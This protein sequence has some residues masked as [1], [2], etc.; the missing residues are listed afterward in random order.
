MKSAVKS[1][2]QSPSNASSRSS[3][4]ESSKQRRMHQSESSNQNATQDMVSKLDALYRL[5]RKQLLWDA[6]DRLTPTKFLAKSSELRSSLDELLPK[7]SLEVAFVSKTKSP[8]ESTI[9]LRSANYVEDIVKDDR[10][11]RSVI[12]LSNAIL[13]LLGHFN[14]TTGYRN[15]PNTNGPSLL[16]KTARSRST[17]RT[18][19]GRG[20]DAPAAEKSVE[21]KH[22]IN[23]DQDVT[24]DVNEVNVQEVHRS[25]HAM[26]QH[27]H[28]LEA[29]GSEGG[30]GA[31]GNI[32]NSSYRA[33]ALD[34]T[35]SSVQQ[36][37]PPPLVDVLMQVS[38][39]LACDFTFKLIFSLLSI[40]WIRLR[41]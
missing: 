39:S 5:K 1:S 20:G 15:T 8:E 19:G 9:G 22:A 29:G 40:L 2:S 6:F 27:I 37:L 41:I 3:R 17:S 14:K 21:N 32:S 24:V 30:D 36:L 26:L 13:P 12:R 4:K 31:A 23:D 11:T 38:I 35:S 10:A 28:R 33:L 16:E 7:P 18:R 34:N 25:F